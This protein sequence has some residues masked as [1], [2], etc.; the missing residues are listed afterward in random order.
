MEANSSPPIDL[1]NFYLV[2]MFLIYNKINFN[3]MKNILVDVWHPLGGM[4]IQE[5]SA[6]R[7]LF[8]FYNQV[9]L[10]RVLT[11]AP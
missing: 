9:D 5:L 1:Y 2:G 10:D 7:F 8:R 4:D 6:K 11:G 3:A